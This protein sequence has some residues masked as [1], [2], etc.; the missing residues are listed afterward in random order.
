MFIYILFI[1][2]S[3]RFVYLASAQ[4]CPHKF[5]MRAVLRQSVNEPKTARRNRITFNTET[6]FSFLSERTHL[7]LH[8]I[9]KQQ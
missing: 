4:L 7:F 2:C 5:R 9:N 6:V 8:L 1:L 3:L